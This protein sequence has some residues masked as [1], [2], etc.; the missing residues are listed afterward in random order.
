LPVGVTAGAPLSCL[1]HTPLSGRLRA[2]VFDTLKQPL[3][4]SRR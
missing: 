3:S 4:I 2:A 1:A